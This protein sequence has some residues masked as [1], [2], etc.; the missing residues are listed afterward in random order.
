VDFDTK[1]SITGGRSHPVLG[2]NETDRYRHV[3][4]LFLQKDKTQIH[5]AVVGY[6]SSNGDKEQAGH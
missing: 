3:L 6:I 2:G 1:I 5:D 4:I